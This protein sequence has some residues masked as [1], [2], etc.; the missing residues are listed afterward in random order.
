MN[1]AIDLSNINFGYRDSNP[2]LAGLNLTLQQGQV[3]AILGQ[4][5]AGK[6]TLI[7]IMLGRIKP[8]SGQVRVLGHPPD[9]LFCRQRV[10]AMMQLGGLPLH[11]KVREF[12]EL[13]SSYHQHPTPLDDIISLCQLEGFLQQTFDT[14]SGGQ[15]Q[16]L[17]MAIAMV[18][19]PDVIFL[20]EP[21][22]GMDVESRQQ[23]WQAIFALKQQNK[24][25]LLTTHYLHEA[26]TLADEL[27]VLREGKCTNLTD[28]PE[29]AN[30]YPRAQIKFTCDLPEVTLLDALPMVNL[31]VEGNKFTILTNEPNP[32]LQRLL[33]QFDVHN[34][35][36]APMSLEEAY[37]SLMNN[38]NA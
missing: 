6:T 19:D 11:I 35:Q 30:I 25:V 33:T 17:F 24:T 23:L 36:V 16:R 3:H 13:F 14:L 9:S 29:L 7:N 37:L 31:S 34:L 32:I 20:D 21:S 22:V 4:N 28:I 2:L 38:G 1:S 10:G 12:I 5:G 18:G 15:K 26:E 27:L 8:T